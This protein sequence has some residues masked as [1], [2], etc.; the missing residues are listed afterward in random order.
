M[1]IRERELTESEVRGNSLEE[2]NRGNIEFNL[3][4]EKMFTRQKERVHQSGLSRS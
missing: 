1:F 4:N 2:E 3:K